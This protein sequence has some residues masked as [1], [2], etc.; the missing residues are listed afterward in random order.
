MNNRQQQRIADYLRQQEA[1]VRIQEGIQQATSNMAVTISRA[2]SLFNFSESQLR[3]WEKR[4]L[5]QTERPLLTAEGKGGTGHRQY[6]LR[7]VSKLAI[8]K[9]LLNHGYTPGEIPVNL[10]ALWE[11]ALG[12]QIA[13]TSGSAPRREREASL[14]IDA[15]VESADELEFWRYFVTQAL[16]LSLLLICEDMP[17]TVAG[18]VL[19]LE[20]SNQAG[21]LTRPGE[22]KSVGRSLVGWLGQNGSFYLFLTEEPVFDFPTDYRLQTLKLASETGVTG[23]RVLDNTFVVLERGARPTARFAPELREAVKRLL[24]LIYERRDNW[25]FALTHSSRGWLYQAHDLERASHVA[26]DRIFNT[27]LERVIDLGGKNEQGEERWRFCAL[28]LPDDINQPVQQQNLVL[29]A[30]TRRSPYQ[31]G[32]TRINSQD[33]DQAS[34]ITLKAFEG[35]QV[36]VMDA[37][38]PGDSMLS[39]L[40]LPVITSTPEMIAAGRPGGRFKSPPPGEKLHSALAVPVIGEHSISI[41]VLYIEASEAQAFSLADLRV[42]RFI[43][44]MLEELIM[45]STAR[46]QRL[47]KR[48][49]LLEAPAI[50][51]HTFG[52]FAVEADF[53]AEIDH[54]LGQIQRKELAGYLADGKLS[55]VAVDI[56]NQSSIAMK[57]GNRVARN[58]SQQV[59][60]RIRRTLPLGNFKLFHISADRYYILLQGMSLNDARALAR[61][62]QQVLGV[63]EYRIQPLSAIAG[64]T[65]SSENMLELASVTVHLGVSTYTYEKL[66]ELLQRYPPETAPIYVRTVIL[67]GMDTKLE[68]GKLE[69]GNC[70]VS[71]DPAAWGYIVLPR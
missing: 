63:G 45:T 6:S 16:R 22:L 7:M 65:A 71:W 31:I 41:A 60:T 57:Y 29:R 30:Q 46:S 14:S 51:D 48:D 40:R 52:D 53:I 43:S 69:G 34:S 5:L 50:V 56:D 18:L 17:D 37:V 19:S 36:V 70:I 23:D 61:Q 49:G 64:K 2:A 28:L 32:V 42:L 24:N 26:G 3:E 11:E 68:R 15:H 54:L 12:A 8:I 35:S 58:L 25:E 38:L 47:M 10:D 21:L 62:L 4:G 20:E 33:A 44:R 1:Q 9:D 66:A 13:L 59:G 27:L 39:P 67:A 55:I